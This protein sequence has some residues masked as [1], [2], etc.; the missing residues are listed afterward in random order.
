M[1]GKSFQTLWNE[2][3]V[4]ATRGNTNG[5]FVVGDL[6]D[7]IAQG[8]AEIGDESLDFSKP[9]GQKAKRKRGVIPP[10]IEYTVDMYEVK[11]GCRPF[12]IK[13]H[14]TGQF[15]PDPRVIAFGKLLHECGM[16][17]EPGNA[18]GGVAMMSD[19]YYMVDKYFHNYIND[20]EYAWDGV[21]RY[22]H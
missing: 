18:Y 11:E 14:I 12:H 21:G 19:T 2:V 13:D 5:D 8:L 7:A 10:Q 22:R 15:V 1:A 20:L 3:K 16:E 6:M 4:K 17:L 9:A